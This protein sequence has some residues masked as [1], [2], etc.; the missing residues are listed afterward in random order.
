VA[1]SCTV[2]DW[3]ADEKLVKLATELREYYQDRMYDFECI[4]E[5]NEITDGRPVS[6]PGL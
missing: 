5:Y 4:D 3:R 1:K 6:Y 2:E